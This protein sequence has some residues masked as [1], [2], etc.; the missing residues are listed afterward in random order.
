MIFG[1]PT[2]FAIEAKDDGLPSDPKSIV[3]GHMRIWCCGSTIGDFSEAQ[4]CLWDSHRQLAKIAANL[5]AITNPE[6]WALSDE[7][8]WDRFNR[9]RYIDR[10]Q[11]NDDIAR[12]FLQWGP[13]DFLTN[14]GEMFDGYKGMIYCIPNGKIRMLVQQ[15]D[16]SIRKYTVSSTGFTDAIAEFSRWCVSLSERSQ[17]RQ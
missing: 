14:W 10:G 17:S 4:S 1:S 8:L 5:S 6:F 9:A 2:D 13:Y 15:P 11:S 3:C 7:A 12:D 16:D